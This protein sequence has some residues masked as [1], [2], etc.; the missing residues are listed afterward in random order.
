MNHVL[1]SA[2][3]LCFSAVVGWGQ[4]SSTQATTDSGND[5]E[6]PIAEMQPPSPKTED[7]SDDFWTR[8]Y[9]T[10]DWD[11]IKERIEGAVDRGDITRDE[12]DAK[13]VEIK[14][15]IARE[16]EDGAE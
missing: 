12:A 13:Y 7:S 2:L 5:S 14:K 1:R 10:G 15:E 11:A 16:D 9:M 4:E 3:I 8:K 6:E